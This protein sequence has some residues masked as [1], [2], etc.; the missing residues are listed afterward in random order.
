[1][2]FKFSKWNGLGND[3]IIVNCL[4]ETI[5]NFSQLA[6]EICDRRFGVGADGLVLL[7]PSDKADYR[8]RIFNSD[9]SEP[10]MCGNATRCVAKYLYDNQ[11]LSANLFTLE[12]GAGIIRPEI[13]LKD[14]Q[15]DAV[16]VDM[17]EPIVAGDLIPVKG[18][19]MEKVVAQPITVLRQSYE[20]TAIS[21]GNPHCV[22]FVEDIN[23][24]EL[25]KVG[26]VLETHALFPKK[27]NV[28]FVE[29]KDR[30]HLRMRV[31]ERGAGITMACGTG[32]CA[33]LVAAV[34]ND[35]SERKAVIELDGGI[36]VIEWA[37]DNHIYMS[38]PAT[39]VF[40][41]EYIR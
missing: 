30:T 37:P 20:F 36:L 39:E 22:I 23:K 24:V 28:E 8:M 9:G 34:L 17:G 32:S 21:M 11:L 5:E 35:R 40:R 12:T 7:L 18:F 26:P 31:W 27:I 4:E 10:E 16:K 14:G 19:G 15:Y 13:I 38:G 25:E 29:V 33:T 41:G 1:M 3:F 2:G 6:V